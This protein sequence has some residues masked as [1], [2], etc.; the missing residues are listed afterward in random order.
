MI[1]IV[2][3]GNHRER[4]GGI[5]PWRRLFI[6]GTKEI[7]TLIIIFM[8]WE[9]QLRV[10]WYE[11]FIT[12]EYHL[13][14]ER[15]QYHWLRFGRLDQFGRLLLVVTMSYWR[16]SSDSRKFRLLVGME[17][18]SSGFVDCDSFSAFSWKSQHH[19]IATIH[20]WEFIIAYRVIFVN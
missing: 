6:H 1:S 18:Q 9:H 20:Y 4:Y 12:H 17:L 19:I 16:E 15:L 14:Y 3:E 7:V 11:L 5:D 10:S 13:D 8:E 2:P